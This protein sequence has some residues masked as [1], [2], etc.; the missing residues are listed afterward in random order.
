MSDAGLTTAGWAPQPMSQVQVTL[1]VLSLGLCHAD[2]LLILNGQTQGDVQARFTSHCNAGCNDANYVMAAAD[3][4]VRVGDLQ[5][6]VFLHLPI[7]ALS[8]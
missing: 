5:F 7:I 1:S 6:R 8:S 4:S 2:G 3:T